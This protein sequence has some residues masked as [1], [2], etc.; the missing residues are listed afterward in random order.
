MINKEQ[1]V[2]GVWV[3]LV[4]LWDETRGSVRLNALVQ[5]VRHFVSVGINGLFVL[6]T[7]GEWFLYTVEER[8]CFTEAVLEKAEGKLPVA[9]HAGHDSTKIAIELAVHARRA[10]AQLVSVSSP[11]HYRLD[12]Q[13]LENHFVAFAEAVADIPVLLYDVPFAGDNVINAQLLQRIHEKAPNVIGAKVSRS[14]W[15][16]WEEYLK[17]VDSLALF[18]GNDLLCLAGLLMGAVGIISGPANVFPELYVGLF[19]KF[20]ENDIKGAVKYQYL[21]N[22][23]CRALNYGQPLAYIKTALQKLGWDVGNVR[24]PLRHLTDTEQNQ[25]D[26]R[27]K[28]VLAEVRNLENTLK[29]GD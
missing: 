25:L 12:S 5:L 18:V 8:K 9:V 26:I 15:L 22:K 14:D 1:V 3:A 16:V 19:N 11:S 27:I 6:G 29:G 2:K 28:E 24:L 4:T 10:G 17:L 23:L 7:T 13:E 20:V 21:I